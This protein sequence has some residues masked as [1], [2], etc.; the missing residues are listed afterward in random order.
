MNY[1]NTHGSISGCVI[2]GHSYPYRLTGGSHT[3]SGNSISG[4]TYEAV[5][6]GG[7]I[8][9]NTLWPASWGLPIVLL[10]DVIVEHSSNPALTVESGVEVQLNDRQIR[11]GYSSDGGRLIANGAVFSGT[12]S[13]ARFV[14][15][16]GVPA[17]S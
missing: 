9:K 15:Q 14:V 11:T 17:S 10:G 12:G 16:R 4:N 13:N 1:Q 2:G 5:A 8:F 3:L 7:T 6:T